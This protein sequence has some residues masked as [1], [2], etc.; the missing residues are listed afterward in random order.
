[1]L[2]FITGGQSAVI[3][4]VPG[5]TASVA[6]AGVVG[7]WASLLLGVFGWVLDAQAMVVANTNRTK[8]RIDKQAECFVNKITT[9]L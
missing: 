4:V 7:V 1:M 9:S 8:G 3:V 5:S 6:S 2:A